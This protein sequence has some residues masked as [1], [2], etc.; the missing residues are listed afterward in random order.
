MGQMAQMSC[1]SWPRVERRS[2]LRRGS[3]TVLHSTW[4]RDEETSRLPKRC[5]IAEQMEKREISWEIRPCIVL[6]SVER[7]R[8]L[9]SSSHAEPMSMQKGRA[10]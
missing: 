1:V 2:T 6:S 9:L 7:R 4:Q 5:W 10:G 3:S 8:W